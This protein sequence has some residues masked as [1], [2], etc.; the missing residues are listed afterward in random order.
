MEFQPKF[1]VVKE[2]ESGNIYAAKVFKDF[3]SYEKGRNVE[4][5][6]NNEKDILLYL[7]DNINNSYILNYIISGKGEVIRK[8]KPTSINKYIIY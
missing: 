8:N 7:Y 2:I 4:K 6:F 1:F 5:N 3:N